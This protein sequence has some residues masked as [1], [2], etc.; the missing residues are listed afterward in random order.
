MKIMLINIV[1]MIFAV[2]KVSPSA[3]WKLTTLPVSFGK[4]VILWCSMGEKKENKFS[5]QRTDLRQWTG[6]QQYDLLC[7]DNKCLNPFKYEMLTRNNTQDFG[8]LIHN[9]S[10]SDLDCQYTCSCGFSDFTKNLSVEPKHVMSLPANETSTTFGKNISNDKMEIEIML[11][12]VNPVPHCSALFKGQFINETTVTVMKWYKYYYDVKVIYSF[13]VD[14]VDCEGRL[15]ILCN[16]VYRNVTIF[17]E[18]MDICQEEA[19]MLTMTLLVIGFSG[20]VIILSICIW[21]TKRRKDRFGVR[22]WT[23]EKKTQVEK[24]NVNQVQ[25]LTPSEKYQQEKETS[26]MMKI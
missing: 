6:G 1:M 21:L 24:I 5:K 18:Y 20:C 10:E 22:C 8:L 26:T 14:D 2:D 7:M 23:K 16:L 15:Q 19:S 17:D 9:L 12:K 3:S 25:L 11:Y 4:D 13:A